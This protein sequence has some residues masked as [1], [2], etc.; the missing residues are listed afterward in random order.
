[1]PR[2]RSVFQNRMVRCAASVA[3]SDHCVHAVSAVAGS[4]RDLRGELRAGLGD[5]FAIVLLREFDPLL[6]KLG[7]LAREFVA[8]R[9]ELGGI[10]GKTSTV[11]A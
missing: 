5:P 8:V 2:S 7:D 6:Q 9:G 3:Y 4:R 10:H 1:M 11:M